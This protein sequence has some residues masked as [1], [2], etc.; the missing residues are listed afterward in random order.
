MLCFLN[1]NRGTPT[2]PPALKRE[3]AEVS[4]NAPRGALADQHGG[5]LA[6]ATSFAVL[7][8]VG[9]DNAAA[10]ADSSNITLKLH[11]LRNCE[12]IQARKPIP[13]APDASIPPLESIIGLLAERYD[14]PHV[15]DM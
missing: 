10:A 11:D 8:T 4:P 15:V 2:A 5:S 9:T 12:V 7:P 6:P 1:L 14:M 3:K 13:Q